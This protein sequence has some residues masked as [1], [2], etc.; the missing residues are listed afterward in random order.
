M[1]R[2]LKPCFAVVSLALAGCWLSESAGASDDHFA[3]QRREVEQRRQQ[4]QAYTTVKMPWGGPT[5]HSNWWPEVRVWPHHH[6]CGPNRPWPHPHRPGHDV[7]LH[8]HYYDFAPFNRVFI[9]N[10]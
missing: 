5:T 8:F 1:R 2:A 6:D 4:Q 7:H 9:Q 3:R 10:W